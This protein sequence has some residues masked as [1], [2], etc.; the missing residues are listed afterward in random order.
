MSN[1]NEEPNKPFNDAMEHKNKIEGFTIN[2]GGRLPLP[3]RLIGY[4]MFGGIILMILIG[5]FANI[6]LN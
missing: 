6:F 2:K 4:F 5:L 3:I 1:H